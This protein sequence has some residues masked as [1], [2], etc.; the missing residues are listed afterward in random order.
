VFLDAVHFAPHGLLDVE[1]WGCDYL[2]CS[3]YKFFGP[4]VG[5]LWGRRERLE[6]LA[7]YKV[8]PAAD[9]LPD[10]WMTGTQNHEGI[11][12]V[13][14][15][16]EYL[17]DLGRQFGGGHERRGAIVTAMNEIGAYEQ[18]LC[19]ELIAGLAEL[20]DVRVWGITDPARF[21]ERVPTI[22]ITHRKLPPVALAEYLASRGIFA[23]H[24]NFYALELS[25]TLGLEPTGLVRLGLL[26]YNT[27]S[28]VARLLAVLKE[29]R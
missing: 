9:T 11:A 5:I 29:L 23:W 1:G 20:D 2:A 16:I 25:E 3:A 12:G 7:A 14:A 21:A 22:A 6:R 17:A 26:H 28:E 19:R 24:G 4:H 13:L 15:A 27:S 18:Q 8:R 10:K